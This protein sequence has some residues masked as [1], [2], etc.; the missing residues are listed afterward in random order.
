MF[1]KRT[2]ADVAAGVNQISVPP[3]FQSLLAEF[4][5]VTNKEALQFAKEP[6][7]G[8][9]HTIE[10]SGRP[11]FARARRLD[12]EKLAAAKAEFDA[13]EKAGI[14]RRSNGPWASP[15]HLMVHGDRRATTGS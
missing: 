10:T 1:K 14:I 13:M 6:K 8:V 5:M 2:Y 12:P 7:H 11:V 9:E 4:P 3:E 15:L